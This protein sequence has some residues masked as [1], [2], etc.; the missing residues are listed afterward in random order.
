MGNE[1][2][3]RGGRKMRNEG[4]SSGGRIL[5]NEGKG[6]IGTQGGRRAAPRKRFV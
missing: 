1:G 5:G 2:Q 6:R 4:Q 3:C